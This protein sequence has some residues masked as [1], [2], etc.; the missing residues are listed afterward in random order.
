MQT[1]LTRQMS[2]DGLPSV[3]LHAEQGAGKC[4]GDLAFQLNSIFTSQRLKGSYGLK[5][6]PEMHLSPVFSPNSCLQ[7]DYSHT[8]TSP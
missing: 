8:Y 1:H 7:N 3:Q 6:S 2:D 4:F 5:Q